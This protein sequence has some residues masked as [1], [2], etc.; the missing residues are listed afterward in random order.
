MAKV[1]CEAMGIKLTLLQGLGLVKSLDDMLRKDM[2][3]AEILVLP[4]NISSEAEFHSRLPNLLMKLAGAFGLVH[5]AIVSQNRTRGEERLHAVV[6]PNEFRTF[7]GR[8]VIKRSL[9][10]PCHSRCIAAP[11][12]RIQSW[13]ASCALMNALRP[14]PQDVRTNC[15][16]NSKVGTDGWEG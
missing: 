13:S 5:S 14:Q 3:E 16:F 11:Q 1:C 4:T 9:S 12:K 15:C 10:A 7:D 2:S 8:A 6:S